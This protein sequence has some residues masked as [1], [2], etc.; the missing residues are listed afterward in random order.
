MA[1]H[2]SP[3]ISAQQAL[4]DLPEITLHLENKL[5]RGA[6]R[7][8]EMVRYPPKDPLGAYAKLMR[9]WPGFESACGISDHVIRYLPRDYSLFRRM[10][11]GDQYPQAYNHALRMLEEEIEAR[12]RRGE[13]VRSGSKAYKDLHRAMVPSLRFRASFPN[14]WRK[15][16]PDAP[17][18]TLMAH[19]GKDGYSHIHYDSEQARTISVREAARLQS[20]SGWVCFF[21]GL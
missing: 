3:A 20:F 13:P 8:T 1:Q 21:A 12:R 19:L 9:G 15:M 17:A 14:K 7:F 16:E 10:D 6:R 4:S 2:G 5:R 18:R 11:P